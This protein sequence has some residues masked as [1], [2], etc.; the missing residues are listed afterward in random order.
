MFRHLTIAA[1]GVGLAVASGVEAATLAQDGKATAAVVLSAKAT[2]PEQ[3]AARELADYLSK[4][5]GGQFAIQDESSATRADFTLYI[6][7]TQFAQAQGL[8]AAK[9]GPEEWLMRTVGKDLILIGGRPRGTLYAVYRFLEDVV[10]VHWWSPWEE[11]VPRKPT[12]AVDG[13]DR[14]GKPVLAYRDIYMLYG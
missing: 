3:T 9:L 4:V 6:G 8:D 14:R 13:L 1:F 2:L 11:S 7:P 5:T 12:L 10:G